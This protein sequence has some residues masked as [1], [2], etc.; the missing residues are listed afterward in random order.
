MR[1]EVDGI[2]DRSEIEPIIRKATVCR[3]G[4]ADNGSPVLCRSHFSYQEGGSLFIL[5]MKE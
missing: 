5:L 4:Y 1:R 2:S 3:R